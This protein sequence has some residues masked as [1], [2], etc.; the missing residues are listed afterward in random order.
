M[1][2]VGV[3]LPFVTCLGFSLLVIWFARTDP[4]RRLMQAVRLPRM[5]T[6]GWMIL[7]AVLGAEG[8]LVVVTLRY[9]GID[10]SR[11]DWWPILL[12]LAVL[13]AVAFLPAG[14]VS[15]HRAL[16]PRSL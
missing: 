4:G 8:G 9:S 13:H 12:Q 16:T 1:G 14:I 3:W 6:R 5:T 2:L 11:T 15:L 7:V 10:P